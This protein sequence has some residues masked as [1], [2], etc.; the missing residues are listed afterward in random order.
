MN[1]E[2]KM[3]SITKISLAGAAACLM[4]AQT[5][6]AAPEW[7]TDVPT[8]QLKAKAANKLVLLDFT[9]SDWCGWC[10]KLHNEVFSK[11][12]FEVYAQ[13]NFVLVEVDFPR[14]KKQSDAVKKANQALAEKYAI[15]G[16]PTIIILNGEGKKVGQLGYMAGGPKAFL[17]AL[18]KIRAGKS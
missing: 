16:Y 15:E 8:A 18:E 12:E 3:K 4:L 7:L 11:P 1:Y 5:C 10:I 14:N 17:A 2:M 9:G 13:K 6:L